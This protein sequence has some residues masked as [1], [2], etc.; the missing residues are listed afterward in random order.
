MFQTYNSIREDKLIY[1]CFLTECVI[2]T[3]HKNKLGVTMWPCDHALRALPYLTRL[4]PSKV[5]R[6]QSYKITLPTIFPSK[7][8]VFL[9][10]PPSFTVVPKFYGQVSDFFL[11]LLH[12]I[13]M[14]SNC[15][16]VMSAKTMQGSSKCCRISFLLAKFL[17]LTPTLQYTK[18]TK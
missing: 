17:C 3:N 9:L 7:E 10:F 14:V 12:Y 6:L 8:N 18:P 2:S 15:Y 4:M 5:T 13:R 1:D 16:A 11:V